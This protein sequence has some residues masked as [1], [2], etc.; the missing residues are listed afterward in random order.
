M[1]ADGSLD[2][3]WVDNN[4]RYLENRLGR[5]PLFEPAGNFYENLALLEETKK[6]SIPASEAL[7]RLFSHAGVSRIPVTFSSGMEHAG[8]FQFSRGQDPNAGPAAG[9]GKVVPGIIRVADKYK[10]IAD[11]RDRGMAFGTILAHE[12]AH[13]CLME[14]GI[15]RETIDNERLTDLALMVIGFGKLWINGSNP[16]VGDRREQLGYLRPLDMTYAYMEF[17]RSGSVPAGLHRTNLSPGAGTIFTRWAD[18]VSA[19]VKAHRQR[20][21]LGEDEEERLSLERKR[22]ELDG[23]LKKALAGVSAAQAL[24]DSAGKDQAIISR[25]GG[26]WEIP[27]GDIRVIEEFAAAVER[28][29]IRDDL[30]GIGGQL[31]DIQYEV[32]E[33][34][35]LLE[36]GSKR[37]GSRDMTRQAI[38]RY[39]QTLALLEARAGAARGSIDAVASAQ[40]RCFGRIGTVRKELESARAAIASCRDTISEIRSFHAFFRSNPPVWP[41]YEECGLSARVAGF[42]RPGGQDEY[43]SRAEQEALG[44]ES[45]LSQKKEQY[46]GAFAASPPLSVIRAR[47]QAGREGADHALAALGECR[48]SLKTFAETYDTGARSL[49]LRLDAALGTAPEIQGILRSLKPRQDRFNA[50]FSRLNVTAP[51]AEE[52]ARLGR[53]LCDCTTETDFARC[54]RTLAAI[55]AAVMQDAGRVRS[56]TEG[57]QIIPLETH[58]RAAVQAEEELRRI[59]GRVR[60][61]SGT[62]QVYLD[63]LDRQERSAAYRVRL[64]LGGIASSVRVLFSRAQKK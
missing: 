12:I 17:L 2:K 46:A 32:K 20:E 63:E 9:G 43:F 31:R 27:P 21:A 6:Y 37:T 28:N 47:V 39:R 18:M 4:Y 16:V 61:W 54:T 7:N 59:G 64:F 5:F 57:G 24:L 51:D 33:M 15:F 58:I 41:G 45:F 1:S 55:R 48:A 34:A 50:G 25:T 44:T 30:A 23:D 14:K 62:Q 8:E 53:D 19:E 40:E 35:L 11:P 49:A 10:M 60:H 3:D 42:I 22:R 26:F 36:P 38:A 56:R 52:F 13:Y 29:T